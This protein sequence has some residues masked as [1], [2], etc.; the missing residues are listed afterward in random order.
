MGSNRS[1]GAG[2]SVRGG[3][4]TALLA[5]VPA[6]RRSSHFGVARDASD[7]ARFTNPG[8]LITTPLDHAF[9]LD[10]REIRPNRARP[11]RPCNALADM[12]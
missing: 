3:C 4:Y 10:E 2:A 6:M 5:S 8:T 7:A 12:A 9:W 1:I 11:F